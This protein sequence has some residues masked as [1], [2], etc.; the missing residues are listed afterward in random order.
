MWAYGR[1]GRLDLVMMIYRILRHNVVPETS[2][3]LKEISR[4]I[5]LL[6]EEHIFVEPEIRPNAVTLTT[7]IQIMAYHGHFSYAIDVFMDML[8]FKNLE[9]GAP[10]EEITAGVYEPV[11][12]QPSL[13]VFR[14]IFLGFSRHAQQIPYL[15]E[16]NME[17][18]SPIF[19]LFLELPS[20]INPNH[21]TIYFIM[22]A[23]DKAS[24][25]DIKILRDVWIRIDR[26]F[27]LELHKVH[28][29]SR[30]ARLQRLL[31]SEKEEEIEFHHRF[32]DST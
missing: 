11:S 29:V 15:S 17:S 25:R 24:G 19:D 16:W 8:S 13:A 28:S 26:R 14:A 30:L 12:Y 7:V 5:R 6:R 22:L 21:N 4:I 18:L 3:G 9:K 23:F 32:R 2:T 31:F 27:G 1:N 10:V 20:N